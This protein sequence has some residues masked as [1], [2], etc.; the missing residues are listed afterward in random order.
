M[1]AFIV[2]E[3]TM[4]FAVAALVTDRERNEVYPAIKGTSGQPFSETAMALA[5]AI[6][7][8]DATAAF[9]L[10]DEVRETANSQIDGL[11]MLGRKLYA[12]NQRAIIERYGDR[13][14]DRYQAIPEFIYDESEICESPSGLEWSLGK[15]ECPKIQSLACLIYQCSEGD[16]PNDPLYVRMTKRLEELQAAWKAGAAERAKT[17]AVVQADRNA[18][19]RVKLLA[20]NTHLVKVTDKP[21]WSRYRV[22]AENIRRELKRR[23]PKTK[24]KVTSESYS[25]GNSINVHWTDGPTGTQVEEITERHKQGS[26]NGYEDI[27]ECDRD[28]VFGELFGV[29]KYVFC[30]RDWTLEGIR[31][32]YDKLYP[33]QGET[34]SE[35]WN[36]EDYSSQESRSR[37]HW[38]QDAW[39]NCSL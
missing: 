12:L 23:F 6:L 30:N 37:I 32:A 15:D 8:G 9:G 31:K 17:A 39:R 25:G 22:A 38:I 16:V 10:I 4:I 33:G 21:E 19:E 7:A 14:D 5:K 29:S 13:P 11:T 20:E 35:G 3:K 2:N 27:Y 1:S 28:N 24:F 18:A 34:I 36:Q 26:F